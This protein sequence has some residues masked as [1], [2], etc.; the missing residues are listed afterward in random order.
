V[1]AMEGFDSLRNLQTL[2]RVRFDDAG[3]D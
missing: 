2:L 3:V 1:V